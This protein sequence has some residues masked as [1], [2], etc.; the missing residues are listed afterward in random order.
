MLEFQVIKLSTAFASTFSKC[1]N[2][3][4]MG[5]GGGLALVFAC[6]LAQGEGWLIGI[7]QTHV[8]SI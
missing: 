4:R 8:R 1:L 2:S 6:G 7:E 5:A 3:S